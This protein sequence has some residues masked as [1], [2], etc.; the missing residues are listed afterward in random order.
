MLL[1]IRIRRSKT[2]SFR[3]ENWQSKRIYRNSTREI[4]QTLSK[5][6]IRRPYL[7]SIRQMSVLGPTRSRINKLR[8]PLNYAE[9]V[10]FVK[11]S[12]SITYIKGG[13]FFT[14]IF[15]TPIFFTPIFFTPKIFLFLHQIF[16][17]FFTRK[18][19]LFYPNF[20]YTKN[21]AFF[22]S[23]ILLFIIQLSNIEILISKFW[24]KSLQMCEHSIFFFIIIEQ[25]YVFW[26]IVNLYLE[27]FKNLYY[28][29]G[30]INSDNV[31]I[32]NFRNSKF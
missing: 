15:F 20:F 25:K 4:T 28:S 23:K 21:F 2:V 6:L 19:L 10:K 24:Y 16:F 9:T 7:L 5:I 14:P 11:S 22:T 29:I 32:F 1:C 30:L 31:L 13:Y 12:N 3:G 17:F 27:M 8:D 18:F 26:D